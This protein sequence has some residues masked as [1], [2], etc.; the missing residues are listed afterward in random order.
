MFSLHYLISESTRT[1]VWSSSALCH[2][3]N[4]CVVC[5]YVCGIYFL[6]ILL[7]YIVFLPYVPTHLY[8]SFH[9]VFSPRFFDLHCILLFFVTR[10]S[11]ISY[12]SF[13]ER[14]VSYTMIVKYFDFKLPCL[15]MNKHSFIHSFINIHSFRNLQTSWEKNPNLKNLCSWKIWKH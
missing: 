5:L 11:I 4:L 1:T 6:I 2:M 7:L 10:L 15:C 14:P 9:L 12:F 13:P 3:Y 8:L